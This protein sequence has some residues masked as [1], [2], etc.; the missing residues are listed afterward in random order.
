MLRELAAD[1]K[2][3][4]DYFKKELATIRKRQ[5]K[6]ESSFE[7]M[8]AELKALNSRMNNAEE[9][10]CD[11]EEGIMEITQSGQQTENQPAKQKNM[12]AI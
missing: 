1:M 8:K 5:E 12:R 6:L 7:E 10:I 3:N 4:A 11:L 9:R 2:H